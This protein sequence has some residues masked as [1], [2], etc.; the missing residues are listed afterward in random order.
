[1][2]N[3]RVFN[4]QFKTFL[5]HF[6]NK[7]LNIRHYFIHN[8]VE[9]KVVSI[10]YALT[11]DQV[12][13]ILTKSLDVSRFES[14]RSSINLYIL[15]KL[16]LESF[17]GYLSC[18]S[19]RLIFLLKLEIFVLLQTLHFVFLTN[20]TLSVFPYFSVDSQS[21]LGCLSSLIQ[22][23]LNTPSPLGTFGSFRLTRPTQVTFQVFLA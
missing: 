6:R 4:I 3:I 12:V 7:L 9:D 15:N 21:S 2:D 18:I 22:T 8:L 19:L 17:L 23:H 14:L 5:F 11:K 10:E 20:V 1:M 13:N 16:S